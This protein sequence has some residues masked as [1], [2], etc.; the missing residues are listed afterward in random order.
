FFKVI[1]RSQA[2]VNATKACSLFKLILRVQPSLMHLLLPV[3]H[4]FLAA[5]S[6]LPWR[7]H[8]C[9]SISSRSTATTTADDDLEHW[10]E[11]A[12]APGAELRGILTAAKYGGQHR[13][14]MI[15]GS[16]IGPE[17]MAVVKQTLL[18]ARAHVDFEELQTSAEGAVTPEEMRRIV[19]SIQRNG[20]ALKGNLES[21]EAS[22]DFISIGGAAAKNAQL[23]AKLGL[24]AYVQ[25]CKSIEGLPTRHRD[26]DILVV[27]QNTEGEYNQL[28][29][30]NVDG[31][32]ESLKVVTE[33]RCRQIAE[34]AFQTAI[35]TRRKK[36]TAVHKANIMKLSDGL[37][38]DVCRQV[39]QSYPDIEF[40][41]MIVDNCCMQLTSQPQ[42]FDLMLLPNLYGNI[43]GN[44]AA[45]LVGGAGVASGMN[46]GSR[47]AVFECGVRVSG[48]A[49]RGRDLANPCGLLLASADMLEYLGEAADAR[50]VRMAVLAALAGGVRTRD[51][52]GSAGTNE[53]TAAIVD[54]LQ[55]NSA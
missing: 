39:A 34:F 19:M 46:V 25:R 15:P 37:F 21:L 1:H 12:P 17:L 53:V 48:Q 10:L 43:V 7:R 29:H 5:L 40:N 45:G 16:G 32:V 50:R 49:M 9:S 28:E 4:R 27:R 3:R 38:L 14:S 11:H 35:K 52:G 30:F 51:L 26:I 24:F 42:Q 41:D 36:V 23:R 31:V 47:C 6:S 55:R 33:A 13:V 54:W 22:T 44:I 18:A 2:F 20:V 8:L